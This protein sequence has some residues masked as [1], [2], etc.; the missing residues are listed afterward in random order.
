MPRV[1]RPAAHFDGRHLFQMPTIRAY[2]TPESIRFEEPKSGKTHIV[3][4]ADH[5][6]I[7]GHPRHL[8]VDMD[9]ARP[10]FEAAFKSI[11]SF[12]LLALRVEVHIDREMEGGI[13]DSD[14]AII[15]HFFT[16]AGASTTITPVPTKPVEP[17][18]I[19]SL[20]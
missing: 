17:T 7:F 4:Y 1:I 18:G 6:Q 3:C 2:F 16:D 13:A 10:V 8:L 9:A 12:W 11:T 15:A 20:P 5:P 14:L 19:S